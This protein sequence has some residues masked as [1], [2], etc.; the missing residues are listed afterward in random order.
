MPITAFNS[1]SD[2]LESGRRSREHFVA[3]TKLDADGPWVP[4][5]VRGYTLRGQMN[6]EDLDDV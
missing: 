4:Y 1:V 5:T 3:C 2:G 6:T